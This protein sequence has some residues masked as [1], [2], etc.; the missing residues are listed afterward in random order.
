MHQPLALAY[1]STP[2]NNFLKEILPLYFQM[3]T[4]TPVAENSY[5]IPQTERNEL[6]T[7][8]SSDTEIGKQEEKYKVIGGGFT[9]SETSQDIQKLTDKQFCRS[10]SCGDGLEGIKSFHEEKW[11]SLVL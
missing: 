2:D 10:K 5:L 3:D 7:E 1:R 8:M 6:A 4:D 11:K 9:S